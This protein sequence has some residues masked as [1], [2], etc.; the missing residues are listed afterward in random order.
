MK[1]GWNIT[2]SFSGVWLVQAVMLV[3]AV[4]LPDSAKWWF[5]LTPVW[6][7]LGTVISFQC[8]TAI[9]KVI[10]KWKEKQ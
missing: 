1:H 4:V 10:K 3:T 8:G 2:V 5:T 6:C 7:V 9:I